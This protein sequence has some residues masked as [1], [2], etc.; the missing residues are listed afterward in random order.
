MEY[1]TVQHRGGSSTRKTGPRGTLRGQS[2]LPRLASP[3]LQDLRPKSCLAAPGMGL[4]LPTRPLAIRQ[5]G[6]S[7]NSSCVRRPRNPQGCHKDQRRFFAR[8][9]SSCI[10]VHSEF[11]PLHGDA[12]PP[13][14]IIVR[15]AS[16][17]NLERR[18]GPLSVPYDGVIRIFS[19]LSLS[20]M[21]C[22]MWTLPSKFLLAEKGSELRGTAGFLL[23]R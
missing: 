6:Y 5:Y 7:N 19:P 15:V 8:Q 23:P 10:T 20:P 1:V 11:L 12:T 14:A 22:G 13:R 17:E 3:Q 18:P 4:D 21:R 2:P 9:R 16:A